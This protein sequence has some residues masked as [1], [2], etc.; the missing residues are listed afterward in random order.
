MDPSFLFQVWVPERVTSGV[1]EIFLR[2]CKDLKNNSYLGLCFCTIY[3]LKIF[4]ITAAV[5]RYTGTE[6]VELESQIYRY[7]NSI[8][9]VC[10]S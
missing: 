10:Y 1:K 7:Y 8:L 5:K 9:L 3:S 4:K 6:D 2:I